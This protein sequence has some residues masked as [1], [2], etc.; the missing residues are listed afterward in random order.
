MTNCGGRSIEIAED[1]CDTK[2]IEKIWYIQQ[3]MFSVVRKVC[4]QDTNLASIRAAVSAPSVVDI[5]RPPAS[6]FLD[7][8]NT[9]KQ[10][11][12]P[13]RAEFSRK[14]WTGFHVQIKQG[15]SAW[16]T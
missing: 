15:C 14:V 6:T 2:K 16:L 9:N 1:I 8:L 3:S 11:S 7:V 13:E 10:G 5:V 12:V 4:K